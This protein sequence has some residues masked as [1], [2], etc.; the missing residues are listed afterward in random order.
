MPDIKQ[1]EILK[2]KI[3]ILEKKNGKIE[4][5]LEDIIKKMD[6]ADARA[7]E[8]F[9]KECSS[10][11]QELRQTAAEIAKLNAERVRAAAKPQR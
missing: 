9:E 2:K 10:L 8:K 11:A 7:R 1:M 6:G 4:K 5:K 3:N